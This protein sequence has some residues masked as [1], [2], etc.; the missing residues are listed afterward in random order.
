VAVTWDAKAQQV[1]V[2]NHK[3]FQPSPD[4]PLDF[5]L[6]V[7]HT[8]LALHQR[9]NLRQALYDPYQMQ[10]SAQRLQREGVRIEEFPQSVPNLTEASQNLFELI[11]G[12]NLVIY[13]DQAMRVA[14]SRAVAVE[15]SRGWRIAKEKQA[16]KI[17]VVVALAMAA[18]AAVK[19][20][21]TYNWS[22]S[23]I[24]DTQYGP[25]AE[26]PEIVK[27]RRA[28]LVELLLRGERVPF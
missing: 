13:P 5:E 8:L 3:T 23:W 1:R 22:G 17:D 21:S 4:Q 11:K 10:A 6:T 19:G 9:F 28:R 14:I 26:D 7:E 15:T 18:H 25:P 27:E 16:H 24:S 2:V 12:K 20:R